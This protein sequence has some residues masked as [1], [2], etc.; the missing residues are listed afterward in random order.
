[1]DPIKEPGVYADIPMEV[2]H[3]QDWL[4]GPSISS[5]GLRAIEQ[6][7]PAHFYAGWSGNPNAVKE[8]AHALSFGS[9]AH[10]LILGDEVFEDRHVIS[11]FDDFRK[12][13]A[14]EWRDEQ[15]AAGKQVITK[16]DLA[17]IEGMAEALRPYADV[18]QGDV[19]Q[20]VVWKRD[21][22]WLKSR[23][24]VRPMSDTLADYKTIANAHPGECERA[25]AK[26]GYYQQFALAIE[27][28]WRTEAQRI[29]TSLLIF[30]EK[31]P[32]YAVT[33]IELDPVYIDMGARQNARA[34]AIFQECMKR[35]EWPGYYMPPPA[36]P[37]SWLERRLELEQLEGTLPATPAWLEEALA[38]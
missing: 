35:G 30:Q 26:H 27:G 14:R 8:Y 9:A 33:P 13:E 15:V 2:Y 28:L 20:S 38:R 6:K 19:E 3:G 21:G 22:V 7:S 31:E 29:E 36:V 1:M 18:F 16:T 37:P 17:H 25:V 23:M 5:S 24:D 12:K 11:P 10:A 34:L 32:P 4:D